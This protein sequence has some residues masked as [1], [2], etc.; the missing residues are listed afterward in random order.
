MCTQNQFVNTQWIDFFFFCARPDDTVLATLPICIS[1][2]AI[3]HLVVFANLLLRKLGLTDKQL[4]AYHIKWDVS[5]SSFIPL[6]FLP[7]TALLVKAWYS[8]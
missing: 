4:L 3:L 8:L 5:L 1:A 6:F 2:V 7:G